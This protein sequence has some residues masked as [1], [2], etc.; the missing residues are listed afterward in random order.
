MLPKKKKGQT[1]IE[2]LLLLGAIAVIVVTLMKK[3]HA[4]LLPSGSC[5]DANMSPI[6]AIQGA[7]NPPSF[8]YFHIMRRK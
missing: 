4:Y 3:V 1:A 8:R 2:Y 6:C 7:W 5:E